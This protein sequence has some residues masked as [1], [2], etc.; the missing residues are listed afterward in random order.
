MYSMF[1]SVQHT[2]QGK[3]QKTSAKNC[4]CSQFAVFVEI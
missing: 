3:P 1:L 2:E 4:G